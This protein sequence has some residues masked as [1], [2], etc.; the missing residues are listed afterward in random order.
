[1]GTARSI[2]LGRLVTDG[3]WPWPGTDGAGGQRMTEPRR[4]DPIGPNLFSETAHSEMRPS[5]SG[6]SSPPMNLQFFTALG[7]VEQQWRIFEKSADCTVF[8]TFDWLSEWYRQ[9]GSKRNLNAVIVLCCWTDGTLAF[10]L[11]L[12]VEH[13]L[14]S[15]RLTWLG[16]DLCDYNA[17]LLSPRFSSLVKPEQFQQLW[18]QIVD[19]IQD[20]PKLHCDAIEMYKMPQ[21]VAGQ[22]NPFLNLPVFPA[23]CSSYSVTLQTDWEKYYTARRSNRSRQTDRRKAKNLAK[24]G[25]IRFVEVRERADLQHTMTVLIKQKQASFARMKVFDMFVAAGYP[26]FYQSIVTKDCFRHIVHLTRLDVG[27]IPAATGLGLR[28]NGCYYQIM[29]SYDE[30]LSRYSPGRLLFYELMNLAIS[31]RMRVFDF[32]IGDHKYKVEW[33]DTQLQL[34]SYLASMTFKGRLIVQIRSITHH[35]GLWLNRFAW[36]PSVKLVLQKVRWACQKFRENGYV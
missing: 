23:G 4:D 26:D 22:P 18:Q 7:A 2:G 1:M 20:E 14:I 34:F 5:A 21:F 36:W 28:F 3:V 30:R 6:G 27:D 29:S 19:A 10:I 24:L 31:R 17:P 11:P 8:Q 12:A 15:R 25:Q 9:I 35:T 16:S 13:H 33:S 32:T